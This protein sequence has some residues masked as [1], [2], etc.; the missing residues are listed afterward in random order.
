M[1]A[2]G[3]GVWKRTLRKDVKPDM[4]VGLLRDCDDGL[5]LCGASACYNQ[6]E[7]CPGVWCR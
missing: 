6:A 5:L 1:M 4:A 7:K 3:T 2:S